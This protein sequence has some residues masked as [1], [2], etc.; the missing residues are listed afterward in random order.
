MSVLRRRCLPFLFL[1]ALGACGGAAPATTAEPAG[2]VRLVVE[3]LKA[4][5]YDRLAAL[6]CASRRAELGGRLDPIAPL[7]SALP[8][9]DVSNLRDAITVEVRDFN[10]TEKSRSGDSAVVAV[11]GS[12]GVTLDPA[13]ARDFVR[14]VSLA[15]GQPM[16]DAQIDAIL[17]ELQRQLGKSHRLKGELDV[18]LE[19]REWLLCDTLS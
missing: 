5:Q 16:T 3:T 10:A 7:A 14:A 11:T 6:L 17:P 12:M 1:A 4:R 15:Q 19:N 9:F 18:V 13:K 8:S 2:T